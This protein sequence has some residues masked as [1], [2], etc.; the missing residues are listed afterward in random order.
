MNRTRNNLGL[1]EVKLPYNVS[2]GDLG[3]PDWAIDSGLLFGE[4]EQHS[5]YDGAT[6]NDGAPLQYGWNCDL[7]ADTM[8]ELTL[9]ADD[10][11]NYTKLNNLDSTCPGKEVDEFGAD[12]NPTPK[13]W[14]LKLPGGPGYY[15]VYIATGIHFSSVSAKKKDWTNKRAW[16]GAW[17]PPY[18][19]GVYAGCTI[20]NVHFSDTIEHS[21]EHNTVEKI[22][23]THDDIL[24]LQGGKYCQFLN[25]IMVEKL[26]NGRQDRPAMFDPVWLPSS[27]KAS[28][29]T[30]Q[31]EVPRDDEAIGFVSLSFSGAARVSGKY[32]T[33]KNGRTWTCRS[34]WLMD[35][36]WCQHQQLSI[37]GLITSLVSQLHT[38]TRCQGHGRRSLTEGRDVQ[39]RMAGG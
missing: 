11:M 9:Q 18:D 14:R 32:D 30:W 25:W 35:G 10:F 4:R 16:N 38:S 2:Y 8:A 7:S 26:G 37:P 15:R 36:N 1:P 22:V 28:G 27:T 24:E 19:T 33:S 6:D 29:V 23:H 31:L 12:L 39:N 34:R 13:I 20:E 5:Y 17:K 21:W 3:A